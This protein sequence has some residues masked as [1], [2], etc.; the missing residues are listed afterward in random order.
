MKMRSSPK[1]QYTE[2]A[3]ILRIQSVIQDTG[4]KLFLCVF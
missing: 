2:P 4:S 1:P 3:S